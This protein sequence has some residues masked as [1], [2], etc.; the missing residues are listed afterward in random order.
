[1][2][3]TDISTTPSCTG[4]LVVRGTGLPAAWGAVDGRTAP[5]GATGLPTG[6]ALRPRV[7]AMTLGAPAHQAYDATGG[8]AA[9]Q[10]N[11]DT[12]GDLPPGDPPS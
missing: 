11:S 10:L 4:V 5:F 2:I 7:E 3:G 1:M 12:P 6:P 8:T 9:V